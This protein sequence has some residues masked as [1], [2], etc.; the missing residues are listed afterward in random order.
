MEKFIADA[1]LIAPDDSFEKDL[2]ALVDRRIAGEPVAQITG[3]WEFYSL[4]IS[5]SAEVLIP[6][7][8]TEVLVD[9]AIAQL[10]GREEPARVLDL[11]TGTG[12]VGIAIAANVP[13][14]RVVLADISDGAFKISRQ[15]IFKNRLTKSVTYISADALQSP[16]P[17]LGRFDMIVSNPPYIPSGDISGLDSSVRDYEPHLA[18]D[19]GNDGLDFYRAIS[20]KWKCLLKEDGVLAFECG[21]GQARDVAKI[22]LKEGFTDM[23]AYKDTLDIERVVSGK[24]QGGQEDG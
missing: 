15:N 13:N 17:L 16:P 14:C 22:M 5:V 12:C 8:D 19:G 21:I 10:S 9:A 6:R 4:P 20:S 18:L 23:T 11:C 3:E 7:V 2:A 1:Q 24:V